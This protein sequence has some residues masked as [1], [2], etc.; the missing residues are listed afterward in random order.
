[1]DASSPN[2]STVLL[3]AQKA[4]ELLRESVEGFFFQRLKG[5]DGLG[6]PAE[7][8]EVREP[9]PPLAAP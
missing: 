8:I 6:M 9:P 2:D 4:T 3:L 5:E 1:L 7:D